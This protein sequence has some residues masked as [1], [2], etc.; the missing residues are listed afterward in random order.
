MST[1][2]VQPSGFVRKPLSVILSEIEADMRTTLGAGV[3]QSSE[4]PLGQINGIYAAAANELWEVAEDIYQSLDPD[5]AESTRLDTL[6]KLRLLNRNSLTDAELRLAISNEGVNK[7]NLKDVE[8]ALI[9]L[10]GI[11]YLRAFLNDDGSLTGEGLDVGDAAL[12][13]L[14]GDNTEIADKLITVMPI[15]GITY[16]NTS[17][18]TSG[19]AP[20]AQDFKLLRLTEVDIAI[21][22]EF[23]AKNE[24][25]DQFQ[26]D[27]TSILEGFATEWTA[28]R[29]N[30]RDVD[31]HQINRIIECN[32]PTIQVSS[33]TITVDGGSP[34]SPDTAATI[35]FDEIATISAENLTGVYV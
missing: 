8:Q 15:G 12:A 4:S 19:G 26:V 9:G 23:V 16:G 31:A 25:Y 2:G 1:F 30:G 34:L 6:S 20:V 24:T 10:D 11:T 17:I 27:I 32:Y 28:N 7:F 35:D 22:F 18:S 5:Q 21:D 33:F 14:G 29:L 3:I 13:I